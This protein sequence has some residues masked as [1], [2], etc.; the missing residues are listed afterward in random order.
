[1]RTE[2]DGITVAK[3]QRFSPVALHPALFGVYLRSLLASMLRFQDSASGR[4]RGRLQVR[5][6][7]LG[8]RGLRAAQRLQAVVWPYE[9]PSALVSAY[10]QN[11]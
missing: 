6:L 1:M 4:Q 7:T 3:G 5:C 2:Y 8:L 10:S 9:G 11:Q